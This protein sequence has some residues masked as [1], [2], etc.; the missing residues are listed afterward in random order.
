[1]KKK[2]ET[3]K[4]VAIEE[5]AEKIGTEAKK[6]SFTVVL[7]VLLV[8]ASFLAGNMFSK[9]KGLKEEKVKITQNTTPT[10]AV[11]PTQPPFQPKKSG[12]PEIKFFVMAYCPYGNQAEA[13]L[14]PVANLLGD[15]VSWQPRYVIYKDY[16][17]NAPAD[18]KATCEKQNCFKTGDQPYC[19][20]HGVAE[21]NEDIREICAARE[22]DFGKWW[23]FVSG[24]NV[25]CT[26]QNIETCWLGE[27]KKAGLNTGLIES[28]FA[29]EKF[30]LA[31]TE[32]EEMDK[33]QAFGSPMV[34]INE[35]VYNGGRAP[36]DY[37]KA[38]CASFENPPAECQK[39]LGAESPAAAG[40]CN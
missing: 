36:E 11:Q 18:Q 21:L 22:N 37:K 10:V 3:K 8:V 14:G 15:K 39:T 2:T 29:K 17:A 32:T 12:K 34:F 20:M 19:S 23:Q 35:V 28:C 38:I 16:C 27:A 30:T 1:M 26:V 25:N 31:K 6:P 9:L 4:T 5:L 7:V 13:G 24:T 33:Y 40:G